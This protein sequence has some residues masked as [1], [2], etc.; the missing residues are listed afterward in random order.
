MITKVYIREKSSRDAIVEYSVDEGGE[1]SW[2]PQRMSFN[3]FQKKYH[4]TDAQHNYQ[5]DWCHREDKVVKSVYC[6]TV[7]LFY[8][9]IGY[10]HKTKK[11]E[12][13]SDGLLS[14]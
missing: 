1:T 7:W 8:K 3:A 13:V 11:F 14:V 9:R 10:N 2:Y 12:E 6:E 5:F 4:F